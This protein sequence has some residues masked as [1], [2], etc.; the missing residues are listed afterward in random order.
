M[1]IAI[2]EC[3][4]QVRRGFKVSD[5]NPQLRKVKRSECPLSCPTPDMPLWNQHPKV[6]LPIEEEKKVSCPYCGNQFELIEDQ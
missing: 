5:S 2:L 4:F 3:L 1:P 6:F